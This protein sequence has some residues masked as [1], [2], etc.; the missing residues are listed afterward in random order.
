MPASG[1]IQR[2]NAEMEGILSSTFRRRHE[3]NYAFADAVSMY[4][5]LPGLRGFWP[6]SSFDAS[7]WVYDLSGQGRTLSMAGT[8]LYRGSTSGIR[9]YIEFDGTNDYLYRPDE[10]GTSITGTESLVASANQGLTLGCWVSFRDTLPSDASADKGVITKWLT[11]SDDRSYGL[12]GD[13]PTDRFMFY[14][15]SAG[16]GATSV[17]V[18]NGSALCDIDPLDWQ[19]VAGRFDPGSELKIWVST[20]SVLNSVTN[21]TSIPASIDDNGSQFNIA[22][23]DDGASATRANILVAMAFLCCMELNDAYIFTLFQQTRAMF[24]K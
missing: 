17:V 2:K 18:G 11:S 23:Y 19:F 20:D 12:F 24:G 5:A 21:T 14:V 10:P 4:Q 22:A 9:P 13:N 7:G 16:T 1:D 8:P 6:T 3:Q 15:S